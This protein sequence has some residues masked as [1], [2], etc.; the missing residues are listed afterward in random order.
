VTY[1]KIVVTDFTL[2]AIGFDYIVV[3]L[4]ELVVNVD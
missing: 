1:K 2:L 3:L 4:V